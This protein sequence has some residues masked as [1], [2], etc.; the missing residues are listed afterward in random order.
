MRHGSKPMDCTDDEE[1]SR[2]PVHEHWRISGS[3]SKLEAQAIAKALRQRITCLL[4]R[5]AESRALWTENPLKAWWATM[6]RIMRWSGGMSL[7]LLG[8]CFVFALCFKWLMVA[9][10]TYLISLLA[11]LTYMISDL[12]RRSQSVYKYL[13]DGNPVLPWLNLDTDVCK[14]DMIFIERLA[15]EY[16][17]DERGLIAMWLDLVNREQASRPKSIRI[18]IYTAASVII[19]LV[20]GRLSLLSKAATVAVSNGASVMVPQVPLVNAIIVGSVAFPIVLAVSAYF[21]QPERV[22]NEQ[23]ALVEFTRRSIDMV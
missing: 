20:S 19:A 9:E 13:K 11:L 12:V 17:R 22:L 15:S 14:A 21:S 8:A 16:S 6:P 2:G 3:E 5:H 7:V 1:A 10:I 23:I 18:A 4:K